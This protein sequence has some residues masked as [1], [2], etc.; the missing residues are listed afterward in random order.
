[1]TLPARFLAAAVLLAL[2]AFALLAW[3]RRAERFDRSGVAVTVAVLGAWAASGAVSCALAAA[4]LE[5][6][7]V[8]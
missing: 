3:A 2:L 8:Q 4:A 7:G 1:M 5:G 6:Q